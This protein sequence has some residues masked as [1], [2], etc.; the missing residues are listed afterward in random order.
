MDGDPPHSLPSKKGLKDE[1]KKI[2]GSQAPPQNGWPDK[3]Y[4]Y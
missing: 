2:K 4:K 1:S 3:H